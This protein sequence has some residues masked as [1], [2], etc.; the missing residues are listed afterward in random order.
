MRR[1]VLILCVLCAFGVVAEAQSY[2]SVSFG[3]SNG[4]VAVGGSYHSGGYYGGYRPRYVQRPL[5]KPYGSYMYRTGIYAPQPQVVYVQQPPVQ[6]QTV[7]VAA[8][9]QQTENKTIRIPEGSTIVVDG[10]V[11]KNVDGKII[12]IQAE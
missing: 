1:V 11:I 9:P 8:P 7:Y 4:Y 12:I 6:Q 10:V 2:G 5:Y 3:Y